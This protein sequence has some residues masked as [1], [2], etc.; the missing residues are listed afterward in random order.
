MAA[1]LD[2]PVWFE[3]VSVA[4]SKRVVAV[5]NYVSTKNIL[6]KIHRRLLNGKNYD[7]DT[8]PDTNILLKYKNGRPENLQ[9][10][11]LE[12]CIFNYYNYGNMLSC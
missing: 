9:S 11:I 8:R 5:A 7:L 2:V 6:A 1:E 3:P 4:K 10:L 12:S